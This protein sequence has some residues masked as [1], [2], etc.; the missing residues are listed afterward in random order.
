[1]TLSGSHFHREVRAEPRWQWTKEVELAASAYQLQKL[2]G[3]MKM[4]K[5]DNSRIQEKAVSAGRE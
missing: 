1:M 2:V 3:G 5:R 4:A